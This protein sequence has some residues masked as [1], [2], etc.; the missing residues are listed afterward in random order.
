MYSNKR[1]EKLISALRIRQLNAEDLEVLSQLIET[2][3]MKEGEESIP[4]PSIA[5]LDELYNF[6]GGV[7]YENEIR[8]YEAIIAELERLLKQHK[9]TLEVSQCKDYSNHGLDNLTDFVPL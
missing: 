8:V 5:Q 3:E 6:S 1:A 7:C 2:K 9:Y 4:N